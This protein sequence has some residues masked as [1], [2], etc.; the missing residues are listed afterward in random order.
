MKTI[1]TTPSADIA[2]RSLDSASV[3]Q[4]Q[5]WFDHLRDWDSDPYVRN[6]SHSLE[7]VSGVNVLRASS[8]LRIF[9]KIDGNTV[10]IV[11][12]AKKPA[13]VVSGHIP[14]AQ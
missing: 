12:I 14:G 11:D 13:I 10:T 5:S 8:D 1:V 9:F 6:R 2:L 4:V 3:R 7:A